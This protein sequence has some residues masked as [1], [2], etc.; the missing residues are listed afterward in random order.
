MTPTQQFSKTETAQPKRKVSPVDVSGLTL[1]QKGLILSDDLQI[2]VHEKTL[3]AIID[4]SKSDLLREL[5][6]ILVGGYYIWCGAHYVEIDAM[7]PARFGESRVGAFKFTH[8]AWADIH[9]RIDAEHADKHIVGWYHTHPNLGIFLS[10]DDLF[11]HQHFFSQ[12]WQVALVVDP[13]ASQLAFFQ[14][15]GFDVEPCGFYF[16]RGTPTPQMEEESTS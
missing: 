12:P 11:I 4:Y 14:W 2:F 9:R 8:E 7:L 3:R 6:G 13:L 10:E 5:G 1:E 15:R 16:V